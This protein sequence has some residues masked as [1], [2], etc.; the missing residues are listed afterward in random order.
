MTQASTV[1]ATAKAEIGY[2]EGFSGGH[3]NNIEKY[4]PAVPGLEWANGQAWCATFV[5]WV[6]L[7]SKVADL[8]P[9]T[10]S[11]PAAVSWWKSKGRWSEYP[12]IGAQVLYGPGGGSHTG[13]VVAYD[14][15]NI[16]TIE[17]NTNTDGSAEGDGVYLKTRHRTDPYVYGYGL[18]A[19][20]EGVT[21]ADPTLKGKTGFNF[22]ATATGPVVPAAVPAP[23]PKP[24]PAPSAPAFPGVSKFGPGADNQW[25]TQ[26]GEALIRHGYGKYYSIG[27]G[28]RW[29]G[30]DLVAT[31]AF[32]LSQGW[33]GSGAN[34]IP[35][36][37]TW[38]RLM[39]K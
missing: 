32:Q 22:A 36:P 19:Y 7:T 13:I 33:T 35:G 6:A 10:A 18:P 21:T 39:S 16:T 11:C 29:T 26:L 24:T 30:S 25:V 5:S 37:L 31:K 20:A 1:I 2:Q 9:R 28:P 23:A 38:A 34:G 3:W 17:G 14:G 12:S 15:I 27:A 4:A 8:F